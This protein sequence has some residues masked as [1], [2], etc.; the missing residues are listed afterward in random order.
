MSRLHSSSITTTTGCKHGR[1]QGLL[2]E[3]SEHP[4]GLG[5]PPEWAARPSLPAN[6][7]FFFSRLQPFISRFHDAQ[8]STKSWDDFFHHH[9]RSPAV[10][11]QSRTTRQAASTV[12][13]VFKVR[14]STVTVTS[15][16][17]RPTT[18]WI[19]GSSKPHAGEWSRPRANCI[20]GV[21]IFRNICQDLKGR[22]H[23]MPGRCI[24]HH[25]PTPE[26]LDGPRQSDNIFG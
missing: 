2:P 9:S 5:G 22:M 4:N 14:P 16:A 21:I 26:V 23:D 1:Q 7:P 20:P 10:G 18:V 19:G 6:A 25:Q 17:T 24:P 13:G 12:G 15:H 8:L 3:Q 11:A